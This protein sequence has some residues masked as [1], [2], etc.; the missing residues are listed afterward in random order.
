MSEFGKE[1]VVVVIDKLVLALIVA[2]AGLWINQ[3]LER[4]RAETALR[5]EVA[6]ATIAKMSEV[7]SKAYEWEKAI[8]RFMDG[9]H[10]VRTQASG[11]TNALEKL[12]GSELAPLEKE[13]DSKG[14]SAGRKLEEERF[15]LTEDQYQEFLSYQKATKALV[16]ADIIRDKL[17]YEEARRRWEQVRPNAH[18]LIKLSSREA[19]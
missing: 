7:W 2:A 8:D 16:R 4:F 13:M 5:S 19:D 12:A 17:L 11:D 6:K 15:W 10:K 1:L 9:V 18:R 3:A 14:E